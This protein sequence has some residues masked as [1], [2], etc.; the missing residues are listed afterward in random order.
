MSQAHIAKRSASRPRANPDAHSD[1]SKFTTVYGFFPSLRQIRA[2]A[3]VAQSKSILQASV[4]LNVSQ[5]AV[6]QAIAK[7][8][9]DLD[10]MLFERRS[11]GSYLTDIGK[12]LQE[13]TQHFLAH[14]E[15][16]VRAFIA[17]ADDASREAFLRRI[18]KSQ[19]VALIAIREAGSFTQAA[20]YAGVSQPSIHR[21]ARSLETELKTS[22]FHDT[23]HG[24]MV[25]DKGA[26]L[27]DQLH[28][29]IREFEWA[30]EKIE[31]QKRQVRGRILVGGLLLAGSGFLASAI[32]HFTRA[33]PEVNVDVAH[34]SYDVLLEKLRAGSLDFIV[35]LLKSPAPADDVVEE[36][37]IPDPYVIAVRRHHPLAGKKQITREE[38]A[39][40]DW[41]LPGPTAARRANFERIFSGLAAI[42]R[43]NI[44]THSLTTILLLLVDSDRMTILTESQLM[45]DRKLGH[46][47]TALNYEL[48]QP[49]GHIGVTTRKNWVPTHNQRIFLNFLRQTKMDRNLQKF[50]SDE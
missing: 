32:S 31:A 47:L 25:N 15:D 11:K 40:Y 9:A 45:L 48:A 4:E 41:V 38:L 7:L 1:Y 43:S 36:V 23:A 35:G 18:T 24:S 46:N 8:E 39:A 19:I 2:F 16:A 50:R 27:A 14:L 28:L 12:I 33:H 26:R 3:A 37:L 6:T 17:P 29:A 34:G 22:L 42:P 10:T 20:R 30:Y 5:S 49:H 21:S 44:E 13:H